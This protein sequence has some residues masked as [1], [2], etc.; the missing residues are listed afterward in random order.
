MLTSYMVRCPN[1][2]CGFFGSLLPSQ[3]P[4]FWKGS[5]PLT[6]TVV[7]ECPHCGHHW[8]ARVKGDDVEP[9]PQEEMVTSA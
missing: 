2:E 6:S 3:N 4:D 8:K 9:I 7:F 5:V 1:I